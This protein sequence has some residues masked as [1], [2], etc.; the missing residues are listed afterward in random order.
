M[1]RLLFL[2]AAFLL[3]TCGPAF[4]Q[5]GASYQYIRLIPSTLPAIC[6]LGSV[7]ISSSTGLFY[8]CNP[9]NTWTGFVSGAAMTPFGQVYAATSSTLASTSAGSAGQ[10]MVSNGSALAPT[11]QALNLAS[12]SAITNVLPVANA[13]IAPQTLSS[14]AV[15]WALGNM[16]TKTMSASG[17]FTFSGAT[18][19]Q[20]ITIRVTN[21]A[22]NYTLGW[23]AG[24]CWS[25]SATTCT[26]TAPPLTTGAHTD[27]FTI[28]YDGANY[29]ANAVQ[30]F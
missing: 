26:Q 30:N 23:P 13:T 15:N 9:A 11:Y 2:A 24:V 12:A 6:S 3:Q 8:V 1:K 18:A 16:F 17:A 28:L 7:R 5:Q 25:G 10:P 20:N 14:F 21:T 19:G 4:A 22:S 29:W 27:I